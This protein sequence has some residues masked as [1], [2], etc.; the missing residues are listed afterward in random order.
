MRRRLE[1]AQIATGSLGDQVPPRGSGQHPL[2]VVPPSRDPGVMSASDIP[3]FREL[4]FPT[5]QVLKALGGSGRIDEISEAV[6]DNL[7]FTAE[8]Q[9]IRRAPDHHMS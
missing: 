2:P 4:M 9:T 7:G 5:L 1:V 3:D 8:Q 6:V